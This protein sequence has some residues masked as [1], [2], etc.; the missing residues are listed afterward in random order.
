[1]LLVD[2]AYLHCLTDFES[3][4]VG[5][6]ESHNHAEERGLTCSVW[7]DDAHDAR[8]RQTEA[9]VFEQNLVAEGFRNVLSLNDFVAETVAVRDVYLEFFF[10][11]FHVFVEHLL[12]RFQTRFSLGVTGLW[13]HAHPLEFAFQSLAAFALGLFLHRHASGLLVEPR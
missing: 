10:F 3:A 6:F 7:P 11:L 12:I 4:C 5:F 2:I 9:E 8:W 1:M 13:C